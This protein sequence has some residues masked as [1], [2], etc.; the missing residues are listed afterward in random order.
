M[1]LNI[2]SNGYALMG[3][4]SRRPLPL[5]FGDLM[6]ADRGQT[7]ILEGGEAPCERYPDGRIYVVDAGQKREYSP[8]KIGAVWVKEAVTA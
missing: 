6:L 8:V 4:S 7:V 1:A 2:K 3:M 5:R